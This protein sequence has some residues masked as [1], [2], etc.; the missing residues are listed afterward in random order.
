MTHCPDCHRL[1]RPVG[2]HICL[3]EALAARGAVTQM[4]PVWP[5]NY[6]ELRRVNAFRLPGDGPAA[7]IWNA[8]VEGRN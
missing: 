8:L 4:K 2:M 1:R 6:T 7:R 5:E 3:A